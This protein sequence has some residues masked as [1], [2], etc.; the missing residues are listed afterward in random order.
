MKHLF[1]YQFFVLFIVCLLPSMVNAKDCLFYF[2]V[3]ASVA[4]DRRVYLDGFRNFAQNHLSAGDKVSFL[5][6]NGETYNFSPFLRRNLIVESGL[7]STREREVLNSIQSSLIVNLANFLRNTSTAQS[8]NILGALVSAADYFRQSGVPINQRCVVIFTDGMES[9]RISGVMM[10]KQIPLRVPREV[11]L[12]TDLQAEIHMI[13]INPPRTIGAQESLRS[14]WE[15]AASR[16]R[17]RL[18][19]YIRSL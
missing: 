12:P 15:D 6:L 19:H 10:D 4:S 8:T 13:G 1:G 14:F 9:S 2:D 16:T 5:S 3:S 11:S 7:S 17:S 18:A